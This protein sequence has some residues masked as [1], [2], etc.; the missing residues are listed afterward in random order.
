MNR[1]L[2]NEELENKIRHFLTDRVLPIIRDPKS[3]D[4]EYLMSKCNENNYD[5][6]LDKQ[7]NDIAMCDKRAK[8]C[9]CVKEI[10]KRKGMTLLQLIIF[11]VK[12]NVNF[13][14][15]SHNYNDS[16]TLDNACFFMLDGK[17]S[18]TIDFCI[19]ED[20]NDSE[21]I[22]IVRS[23]FNYL[24]GRYCKGYRGKLNC[25]PSEIMGIDDKYWKLQAE[26][27][28]KGLP[29]LSNKGCNGRKVGITQ[30]EEC[31]DCKY[32][33]IELSPHCDFNYWKIYEQPLCLLLPDNGKTYAC[34]HFKR[35]K[36]KN[37][38]SCKNKT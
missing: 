29:A 11:I 21:L 26:L 14:E 12:H 1:K 20:L 24:R 17:N 31:K 37:K 18:I 3:G 13:V 38:C 10:I 35:I 23:A 9:G 33:A 7:F 5:T 30:N 16:N 2:L 4:T 22:T 36:S 8:H 28:Y 32:F 15:E 34:E 25:E 27:F 6:F 19:R